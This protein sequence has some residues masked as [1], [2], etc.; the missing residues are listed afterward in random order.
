MVPGMRLGPGGRP[1]AAVLHAADDLC[2]SVAPPARVLELLAW[3]D[4]GRAT[5]HLHDAAR[6]AG[7][8]GAALSAAEREP[9]V[10][11]EELV[12][13][14]E[15]FA[16]DFA[17]DPA[18]LPHIG[19]Q[20][21]VDDASALRR[22]GFSSNRSVETFEELLRWG[23]AASRRLVGILTLTLRF[24]ESHAGAGALPEGFG[25]LPATIASRREEWARAQA[26]LDRTATVVGAV[27]AETH[28]FPRRRVLLKER[29]ESEDAAVAKLL[30][31]VAGVLSPWAW[32][33]RAPESRVL[34]CEVVGDYGLRLRFGDGT[35]RDVE[36]GQDYWST[37]GVS[38]D[39]ELFRSVCVD[40]G[41]NRLV[42]PNGVQVPGERLHLAIR[43]GRLG[44]R[45]GE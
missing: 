10:P 40:P 34:S 17:E 23:A 8:L 35:D 30:R 42:W 20:E 31:A 36:L 1:N 7:A 41:C 11:F 18:A 5:S 25:D 21:V 14:C 9:G 13:A 24:V 26:V 43:E 15:E 6:R 3:L 2:R 33:V 38:M 4:A 32:L 28:A 27:M 12:P 19:W 22:Y 39:P 44:G 16:R 45:R 29:A 37:T